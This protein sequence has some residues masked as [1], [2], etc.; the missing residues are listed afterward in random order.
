MQF[1]NDRYVFSS[2]DFNLCKFGW[3]DDDNVILHN[4]MYHLV[5]IEEKICLKMHLTK[6]PKYNDCIACVVAWKKGK[7]NQTESKACAGFIYEI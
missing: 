7:M 5:N 1:Q 2:L 6:N 4:L 3:F